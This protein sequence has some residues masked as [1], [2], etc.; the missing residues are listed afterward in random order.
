M[1]ET[2]CWRESFA[3]PQGE[4]PSIASSQS[5]K[6]EMVCISSTPQKA[7]RAPVYAFTP[8]ETS[9]YRSLSSPSEQRKITTLVA[10]P[11]YGKTVLL[12]QLYHH[13]SSMDVECTWIGLEERDTSLSAV[14]SKMEAALGVFNPGRP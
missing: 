11:G 7:H 9:L 2:A 5:P 12:S 1:R 6:S 3:L 13:Y 8:I 4:S 10:P 14:L